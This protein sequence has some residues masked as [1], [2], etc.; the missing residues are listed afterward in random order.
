MM[1]TVA[2]GNVA[3]NAGLIGVVTFFVKRWMSNTEATVKT[4]ASNLSL[5]TEQHSKEI[6]MVTEKNREEVKETAK[7][8]SE[9]TK[10][11]TQ[12]II[13]SLDAVFLQLREANGRTGKN[14]IA[15]AEQKI[16]C[17]ERIRQSACGG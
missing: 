3:I 10:E 8:L 2:W 4:T 12:T 7:L 16:R 5:I 13:R 11:T 1:D 9:N 6:A 14:E 17:E 15:I